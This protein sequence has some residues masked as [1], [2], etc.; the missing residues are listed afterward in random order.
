MKVERLSRADQSFQQEWEA[1][2]FISGEMS[3]GTW[4]FRYGNVS[5]FENLYD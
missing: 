2:Q 5:L 4:T 1:N 3:M